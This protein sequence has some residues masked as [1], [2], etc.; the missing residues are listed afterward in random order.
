M[1][2]AGSPDQGI[3]QT[4]ASGGTE[5]GRRISAGPSFGIHSLRFSFG[6]AFPSVSP[7]LRKGRCPPPAR[8]SV[9][10][11]PLRTR[12]CSAAAGGPLVSPFLRKGRRLDPAMRSIQGPEVGGVLAQALT[13]SV[14]LY[15]KW[16]EGYSSRGST[17]SFCSYW[18]EPDDPG[19]SPAP[20]R[21]GVDDNVSLDDLCRRDS[22]LDRSGKPSLGAGSEDQSRAT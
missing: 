10:F 16:N 1:A 21:R 17:L 12:R 18:R 14:L 4:A 20:Q 22:P 3:A 19:W 6:F 8:G 5:R 7:F 15:G 11:V 2:S 9:G 13:D